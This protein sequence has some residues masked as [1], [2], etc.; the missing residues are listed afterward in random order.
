M[1]APIFM[2]CGTPTRAAISSRVRSAT[3]RERAPALESIEVSFNHDLNGDGTIGIPVPS[4]AT[5]IESSGTT[6]LLASG[7]TYLIQVGSGGAVQ[8]TYGGQPVTAGRI[9]RHDSDRGAADGERI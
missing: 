2:G 5:V 4:S 1:W 9:W 3:C 7:N 6:S 8:L